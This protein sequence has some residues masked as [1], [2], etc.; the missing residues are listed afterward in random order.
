MAG[1]K[2]MTIN[3]NQTT[4]ELQAQFNKCYPFLKIEFFKTPHIKGRGNSRDKMI[5][6]NESLGKLQS[7]KNSGIISFSDSTTVTSL[8]D[9]FLLKYGLNIQVFRKSGKVWLE[10][11]STDDW[12]L[13]QQNDEGKSL[14]QQLKTEKED[15]NDHD[16]Y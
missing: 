5:T 2:Y 4:A 8:E 10:T 16:I 7:K 6:N 14:A 13:S 9:E 11:T 1:E 12:T 3:A 15:T